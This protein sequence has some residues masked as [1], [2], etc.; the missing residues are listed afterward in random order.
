MFKNKSVL[1]GLLIILFSIILD[2]VT[3]LYALVKLK[4]EGTSIE[5]IPNFF[6]FKLHFNDGAAWSSFAGNF[7]FLMAMSILA[8]VVFTYIYISIDFKVKPFYSIGISL[9]FGGLFGNLIDRIF[10]DGNYVVD[11][12]SFK[13]GSYVFPTFNIADCCLVVGVA[14][15]L[16]DVLFLEGKRE[17]E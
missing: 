9:M 13:F 7:G 14:A 10:M 1:V 11:F 8:I 5:V 2:Q 15:L 17:D 4:V 16:I 12:L 3:K 6:N